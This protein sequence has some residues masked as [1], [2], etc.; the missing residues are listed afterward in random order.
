VSGF[1]PSGRIVIDLICLVQSTKTCTICFG[2][3][4]VGKDSTPTQVDPQFD[5]DQVGDRSC[6]KK[7]IVFTIK[8][9]KM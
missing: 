4:T 5:P 9:Y 3:A 8:A 6:C 7:I 2:R 1:A